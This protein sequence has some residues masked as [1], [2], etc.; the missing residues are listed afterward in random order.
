MGRSS[1]V[2]YLRTTT[3]GRLTPHMARV[4]FTGEGL[5]DFRTWPDQQLKLCFPRPGQTRPR[6]PE[7]D[8]D[9]VMGW[10]RA[11]L[12]IP[13]AERPWMRSYTVRAY[14]P[15]QHTITVDFVLHPDAGPAT[16]WARAARPGDV[17]GR[18]GPSADYARPLGDADVYLLAGDESALPAI[19][20]ILESLP[21]EARAIAYVEV[22]DAA[23]EQRFAA[24]ADVTVHWL[25]RGEVPPG[26]A[27]LL[28]DAVRAAELPAGTV[29]AWLAG[30]AAT[31]R[32]L[33][34]HLVGE[35]GLA[36]RSIEFAG[37][38]R[39]ALTQDDAPTEDDR[40]E[41]RE[42]MAEAGAVAGTEPKTETGFGA[43]E[44]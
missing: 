35:R 12:A 42:R 6:L 1:L 23:E 19:G 40:A 36:K 13:E 8:A 28:L 29:R 16:R 9:D 14:D 7:A 25:H 41:A 27:D 20:S 32:A 30:E 24:R 5:D 31:V 34:R 37:Y 44:S 4:T 39:R 17:L 3:V 11:Y 33:R 18:Y 15:E 10:Y 26:H 38:W 21:A 43:Y 2:S 22:R